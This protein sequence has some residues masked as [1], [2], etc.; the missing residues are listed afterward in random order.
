MGTCVY[1]YMSMHVSVG[2]NGGQKKVTDL[3]ELEF[4]GSCMVS[5]AGAEDQISVLWK[6]EWCLLLITEPPNSPPL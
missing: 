5:N 6:N 2:A 1:P 3:L 4:K